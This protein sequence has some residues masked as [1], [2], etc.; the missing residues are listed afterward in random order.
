VGGGHNGAGADAKICVS[1]PSLPTVRF[2]LSDSDQG[3][4]VYWSMDAA[5]EVLESPGKSPGNFCNQESGNH[6]TSMLNRHEHGFPKYAAIED[7]LLS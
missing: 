7:R 5:S 2:F 4:K 3:F 1:A 6:D